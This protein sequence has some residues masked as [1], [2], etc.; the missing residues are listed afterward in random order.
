MVT[1]KQTGE[2]FVIPNNFDF[3]KLSGS[4]F[5]VHWGTEEI[6]V[7][8]LFSK[9]VADYVRERIWHPSQA[10]TEHNNGE[11]SLKLTVN[12]LLELKRWILSWGNEAAVLAPDA[13]ARDIRQTLLNAASNY[14]SN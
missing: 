12:H 3:Q 13:L 10:I 2:S 5:G 7:V 14:L 11:V 1:A 4:R 6:N 9:R 8:I